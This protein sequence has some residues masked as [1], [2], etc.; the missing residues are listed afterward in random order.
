ML[1]G[2]ITVLPNIQGFTFTSV[3]LLRRIY[4]SY[5]EVVFTRDAR[6]HKVVE[7]FTP[8]GNWDNVELEIS[9]GLH[10]LV[11]TPILNALY[12]P[13]I[14]SH[15]FNGVKNTCHYFFET[16]LGRTILTW[17]S[18]VAFPHNLFVTISSQD[19]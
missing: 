14:A 7:T 17:T 4:T 9:G 15:G 10:Y 13:G 11:N 3:D 8:M 19:K 6:T 1:L 2:K 12:I 18:K 5:S 16:A